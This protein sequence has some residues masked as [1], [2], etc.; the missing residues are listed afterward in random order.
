MPSAW[1][2]MPMRPPSSARIAILNPSPSGPRR[3][4]S[5]T[6]Q[7]SRNTCADGAPR[8]P[9]LS[10]GG[11]ILRPGRIQRDEERGD[12]AA[13]LAGVGRREHDHHVGDRR[14][15][16]E[17]LGAVEHPALAVF[18]PPACAGPSRR[19]P[20]PVRTARSSRS[21]GPRSDRAASAGPL[22][23]A[24]PRRG[25]GRRP[26]SFA[27]TS[28]PPSRRRRARSPPAPPRRRGRPCRRRPSVR[29]P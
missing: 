22:L 27:P 29:A 5:P 12:A 16:D 4:S 18:A 3:A 11:P 25:S 19:S 26:A 23:V 20:P 8:M 15:G 10:S 24:R 14:V 9:S 2:A 13:P 6:A 17:V 1:A 7:S 28:R 21:C